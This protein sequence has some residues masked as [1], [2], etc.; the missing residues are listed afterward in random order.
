[1]RKTFLLAAASVVLFAGAAS[2]QSVDVRVGSNLGIHSPNTQTATA[3]V[4]NVRVDHLLTGQA[5]AVGSALNVEAFGTA[6]I[7]GNAAYYNNPYI[8]GAHIAN[9]GVQTSTLNV[10]SSSIDRADLRAQSLGGALDVRAFDAVVNSNFAIV[11]Q[12]NQSSTLNMGS[13][14][15]DGRLDGVS[16]AVGAAINIDADRDV[17]INGGN[18]PLLVNSGAVQNAALNYSNGSVGGSAGL[19]SQAVGTALDVSADGFVNATV[20]QT[21][22]F[23]T[24]GYP[25]ATQTATTNISSASF[26]SSLTGNAGAFGNMVN[27]NGAGGVLANISAQGLN[28][29]Q[30][31]TMNL[32][33]S[34]IGGSATVG[35]TAIGNTVTV[36]AGTRP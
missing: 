9:G 23:G 13:T 22:G 28:T 29:P 16:G 14:R 11:N 2:A 18:V 7:S 6:T 20:L 8:G 15:V 5:A 36:T 12:G 1:M 25:G 32:N 10:N 3:N 24:G 35:A 19:I 21:N 31:A 34:F 17:L 26:G 27:I 33:N 30:I 4:A